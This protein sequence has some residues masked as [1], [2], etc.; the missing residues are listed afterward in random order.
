VSF[1]APVQIKTIHE[2]KH[3]DPILDI[4]WGVSTG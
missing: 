1:L 4:N 3:H 2:A